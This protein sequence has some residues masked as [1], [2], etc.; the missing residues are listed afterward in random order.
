MFDFVRKHTKIVMVLLFLLILP[1]FVLL[2]LDGYNSSK[3]QSAKVAK[4]DGK[5][6]TQSEWDRVHQREVDQLR[7]SM[8]NLDPKLM[9]S[10]EARYASLERL[11]RD[12]VIAAAADKFKLATS[13]Q[14]LARE[15]QQSPEIA[16]LRRPDGSL[17][18]ERYR[19]LLSSQGMS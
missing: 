18:M 5:D 19:Q 1:S 8:P 14:R 6:I 16:S 11:V 17:D 2:G 10:P 4:V 12:R 7:N 13:D 3:D 9:D 15:L